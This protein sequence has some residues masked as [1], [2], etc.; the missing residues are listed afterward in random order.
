V[1]EIS[2]STQS[3]EGGN[4]KRLSVSR[5]LLFTV[6]WPSM[7]RTKVGTYSVKLR[8]GNTSQRPRLLTTSKIATQ[9]SQKVSP[10]TNWLPNRMLAMEELVL[11]SF[12]R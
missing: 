6:R 1:E 12:S 2:L 9:S 7:T 11:P 10:Q 8:A 3:G 4:E 5:A